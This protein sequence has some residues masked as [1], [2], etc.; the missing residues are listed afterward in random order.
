VRH[1]NFVL[2]DI[3]P[4]YK[5]PAQSFYG[6]AFGWKFQDWGDAY[7]DILEAGV[8]GG[9][10]KVDRVDKGAT[11]AI[12]YSS[13]L[14]ASERA[15]IAAGGSITEKHEFPGG[16]RFQFTDPS[17]VELAVWTKAEH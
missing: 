2:N 9:L 1:H 4:T 6:Q 13:D 12:I 17:G 11:L 16:R 15:V 7:A 5:Q 3:P 14:E 10:R 8:S